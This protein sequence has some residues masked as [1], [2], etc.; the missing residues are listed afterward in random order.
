MMTATATQ[1]ELWMIGWSPEAVTRITRRRQQARNIADQ[2]EFAHPP[3]PPPPP[4]WDGFEPFDDG[5]EEAV[6]R[7]SSF[8]PRYNSPETENEILPSG[9]AAATSLSDRDAI[10]Q[11][12]ITNIQRET[13]VDDAPA[14]G[15]EG[16]TPDELAAVTAGQALQTKPSKK[17]FHTW[18]AAS[19]AATGCDVADPEVPNAVDIEVAGVTFRV[20]V[21]IPRTK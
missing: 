9:H 11:A 19:L 16:L 14:L 12:L 18:L 8:A 15:T 10:A 6:E 3:V 5:F 17:S 7:V 21:S 13:P 1:P 4:S 20:Q 2:R